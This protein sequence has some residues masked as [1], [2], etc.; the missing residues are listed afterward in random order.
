MRMSAKPSST[1]SFRLQKTHSTRTA[2]STRQLMQE[3][4]VFSV[5]HS[6]IRPLSTWRD[7]YLQISGRSVQTLEHHRPLRKKGGLPH[8]IWQIGVTTS[9][10]TLWVIYAL[11][12]HLGCLRARTIGLP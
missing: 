2:A 12:R 5:M 3:N 11:E 6:L 4:D 9:P 1:L 7:M 8:K 10:L